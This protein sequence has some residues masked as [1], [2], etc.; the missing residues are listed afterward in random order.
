MRRWLGDRRPVI[1]PR[2]D[3]R[4]PPPSLGAQTTQHDRRGSTRSPWDA[5]T[6]L[7]ANPPPNARIIDGC[8]GFLLALS[9]AHAGP[10]PPTNAWFHRG[11]TRRSSTST[12]SWVAPGGGWPG[13][14]AGPCPGACM[15]I[16]RRDRRRPG[17]LCCEVNVTP[18]N[19]GSLAFPRP[20][21]L[22]GV[23][24]R[25]TTRAMEKARALP[26]CAREGHGPRAQR[27]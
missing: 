25:P 18:P 4:P 6:A 3:R 22:C 17:P 7:V 12:A 1:R 13:V 2:H 21:R 26:Q 24:A 20:A 9:E 15:R 27:S 23:R 10:R 11:A 14:S 8:D 19:P 16:S 5:L